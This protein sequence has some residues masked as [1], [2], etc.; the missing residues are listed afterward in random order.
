MQDRQYYVD[1]TLV[2][3]ECER[4]FRWSSGEQA[5]YASKGLRPPKRC[6]ECRELRR[7]TINSSPEAS[8]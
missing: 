6:P 2:C 7:H 1:T 8:S 4:S 5:Y 3:V